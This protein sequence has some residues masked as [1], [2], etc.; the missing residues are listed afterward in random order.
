MKRELQTKYTPWVYTEGR[1]GW[2]KNP[3][4]IK[5]YRIWLET[6]GR[7]WWQRHE[8][9]YEDGSQWKD[10]WIDSMTLKNGFPSHYIEIEE[11]DKE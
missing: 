7:M 10:E 6:N 8:W 3:T 5:A 2:D 11:K 4:H 1:Y 9:M